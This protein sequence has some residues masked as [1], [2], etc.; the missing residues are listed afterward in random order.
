MITHFSL[1]HH[2]STGYPE[3]LNTKDF[4]KMSHLVTAMRLEI[5]IPHARI[6]ISHQWEQ[7]EK[8]KKID[9]LFSGGNNV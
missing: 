8:L 9:L 7:Y 1:A 5:E 3:N 6:I 2:F 4:L